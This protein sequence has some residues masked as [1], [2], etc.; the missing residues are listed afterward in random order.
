[1][2]GGSGSFSPPTM[3]VSQGGLSTCPLLRLSLDP[4]YPHSGTS[5][6][7][8]GCTLPTLIRAWYQVFSDHTDPGL[9][10]STHSDPG[11]PLKTHTHMWDSSHIHGRIYIIRYIV[12]IAA[13][14]ASALLA[15]PGWAKRWTTL[16][17]AQAGSWATAQM[18]GVPIQ[19]Q[20]TCSQSSSHGYSGVRRTDHSHGM[21]SKILSGTQLVS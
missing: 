16:S 20:E 8:A 13:V 2:R 15:M 5:I 14:N 11:H 7:A 18:A 3:P 9:P 10:E 19:N 12:A 6:S 17:P 4:G 1:M 21:T